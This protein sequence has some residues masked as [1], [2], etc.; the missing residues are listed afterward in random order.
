[1]TLCEDVAKCSE[2]ALTKN[3]R[4]VHILVIEAHIKEV[5]YCRMCTH[6]INYHNGEYCCRVLGI[7]SGYKPVKK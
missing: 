6:Y 4:D 7:W 1:M 5:K 2:V 3:A